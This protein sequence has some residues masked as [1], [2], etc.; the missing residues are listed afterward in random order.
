M[1]AAL[2]NSA[3]YCTVLS[4]PATSIFFII[5]RSF[6]FGLII[7]LITLYNGLHL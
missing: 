2:P 6:E 4:T 3:Q 7:Q 1:G 5:C